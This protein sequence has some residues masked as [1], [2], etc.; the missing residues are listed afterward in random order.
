MAKLIK[1][2]TLLRFYFISMVTGI[3]LFALTFIYT[4]YSNHK[5]IGLN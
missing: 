1:N 5:E 4:E 3:T 2:L